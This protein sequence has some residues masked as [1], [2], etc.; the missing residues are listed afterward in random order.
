MKGS[1][2]FQVLYELKV[3]HVKKFPGVLKGSVATLLS[4]RRRDGNLLVKSRTEGGA[5]GSAMASAGRLVVPAAAVGPGAG[6]GTTRRRRRG[7][8]VSL[9]QQNQYAPKYPLVGL[10]DER[11]PTRAALPGGW[12]WLARRGGAAASAAQP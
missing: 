8:S 12:R 7:S 9:L 11:A 4:A 5:G 2:G 6:D 3:R 10:D 1:S